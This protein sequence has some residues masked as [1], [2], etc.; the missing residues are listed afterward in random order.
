MTR[1]VEIK[2]AIIMP[3]FLYSHS[4]KK[5][6]KDKNVKTRMI[7]IYTHFPDTTYIS[8]YKISYLFIHC[9][10]KNEER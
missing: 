9:N 7:C 4:K 6:Q 10:K 8:G 2:L 5:N 1:Y 3:L